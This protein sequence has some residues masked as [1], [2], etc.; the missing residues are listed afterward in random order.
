MLDLKPDGRVPMRTLIAL[1][2]RCSSA[3]AEPLPTKE[4]KLTDLKP[5]LVLRGS[6]SAILKE[7]FLVVTEEVKWKELWQEHRGKDPKFTEK[8]QELTLDFKTHYL[9]AIF[10]G[11]DSGLSASAIT[12]GEEVLIRFS[13]FGT[14]TREGEVDKRTAHEKAKDDAI[15]QY[16]FLILPKPIKTVVFERDCR[17]QLDHPPLW[18]EKARIPLAKSNK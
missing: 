7:Q 5:T 14:Q 10:T 1:A 8:R 2:V 17:E 13:A 3:F 6:H 12:R 18:K 9:V 4:P 16:A 11:D 15:A